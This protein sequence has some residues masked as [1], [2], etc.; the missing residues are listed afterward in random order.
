[1]LDV[2]MADAEEL[3]LPRPWERVPLPD[4]VA[5]GV[6]EIETFA[7]TEDET[8]S[9]ALSDTRAVCVELRTGLDDEESFGDAEP[10]AQ[11]DGFAL[12]DSVVLADDDGLSEVEARDV[13]DVRGDE[14]IDP[15]IFDEAD[16]SAREDE[17]VTD[18]VVVRETAGD[19]LSDNETDRV[20]EPELAGV[21]DA[22]IDPLMIGD[23]DG[24]SVG[25]AVDDVKGLLDE[26]GE[27]VSAAELRA[28]WLSDG[29]ADIDPLEE[30]DG[31][32]VSVDVTFADCDELRDARA[33]VEAVT[34]P[35]LVEEAVPDKVDVAVGDESVEREDEAVD[36]D[37]AL[38]L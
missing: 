1:M 31:V 9:S 37:D 33:D 29:D 34:V 15:D 10:E 12:A 14:V 11:K 36:E 16:R 4:A 35:V 2:K 8:V 28:L 13:D 24:V 27:E 22:T 19:R 21:L 20:A 17:A 26:S 30:E 18:N 32:V 38:L 3:A 25:G 5:V 6:D 23:D 7:V